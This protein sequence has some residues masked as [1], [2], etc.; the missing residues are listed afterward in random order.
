[1]A[2]ITIENDNK[3]RKTNFISVQDFLDYLINNN[4][5]ED[6]P[7][8]IWVLSGNEVTEDILESIKKT[9]NIPKKDL[10]NI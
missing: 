7:V 2:T 9:K 5:I 8:E 10:I 6:D 3:I 1:M 4:L